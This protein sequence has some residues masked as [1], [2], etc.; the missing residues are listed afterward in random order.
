[1]SDVILLSLTASLNPTLVAATTV[2]LLLDKPVRLMAGYLAGA[3]LTSI[4]LGLIIVF[5]FSDSGAAKTAENSVNPS[6]DIGLGAICLAISFV[7]YTGRVERL[8]QRRAERKAEK[9]PAEPPRWQRELSKGSPRVTFLVGAALTLPGASY[10]AGLASIHKLHYSTPETVLLVIGFN[11]VMM[12]L[13][14]V[15]L[16]SFLIAPDKTPQLISRAKA[17]VSRHAHTFAVRGFAA[18]GVLL[19]IKG[20]I[21]LLG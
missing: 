15:P 3:Y 6:V 12:W 9:G 4:T 8:R 7:F 2:M 19:I 5:S 21:G 18:V 13:L 11:L 16:I 17:W 20:L 10:L 14:E 1:M